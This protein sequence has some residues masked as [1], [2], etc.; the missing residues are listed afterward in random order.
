MV[1]M[2]GAKRRRAR[3]GDEM[4]QDILRAA[5]DIIAEEG[6]GALSIRG[7]ARRI[8]YSAPAL[9]EYFTGKE[10]IAEAL[11]IEGFRKLAEAM[12]QIEQTESD[13]LARIRAMSITYRQFAITHAQEYSLMFSRPIPEFRPSHADLDIA[14]TAFAPLQHA[15]ADGIAAGVI[16]PMDARTGATAA[17]A[18]LHGLVSLELAGMGGP[19]PEH[20]LPPETVVPGHFP[21]LYATALDLF[22]DA[23]RVR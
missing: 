18:Y 3:Y 8:A 11:F 16:R 5:R 6:A 13:P 17:W 2:A 19:P 1:T 23:I 20:S 12:E 21:S 7:I 4:R 9:Y 22:S 14:T 15:F 10:A